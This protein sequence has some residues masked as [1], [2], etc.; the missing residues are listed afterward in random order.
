MRLKMCKM[1]FKV[2]FKILYKNV[3]TGNVKEEEKE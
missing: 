1:E 3:K 2:F